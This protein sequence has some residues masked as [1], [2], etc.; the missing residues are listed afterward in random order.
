MLSSNLTR[1]SALLVMIPVLYAGE[2][3]LALHKAS[4]SVDPRLIQQ[5]LAKG[6]DAN[7]IDENSMTPL[8]HVASGPGASSS[9]NELE[10]LRILIEAGALLDVKTRSGWS[11]LMQAAMGTSQS[12]VKMLLDHGA[13]TSLIDNEGFTPLMQATMAAEMVPRPDQADRNIV[14]ML[15]RAG[16]KPNYARSFDGI[17]ALYDSFCKRVS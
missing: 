5:L 13:N 11:A 6:A 3:E 17:T 1:F 9:A 12:A 8:M 14:R 15:L 7:A 4:K 2:L 16:A 10:A